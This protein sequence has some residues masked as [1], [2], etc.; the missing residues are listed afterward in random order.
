[1]MKPRSCWRRTA[2]GYPTE[3]SSQ[4]VFSNTP[5]IKNNLRTGKGLRYLTEKTQGIRLVYEQVINTMSE[6]K[7]CSPHSP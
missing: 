1:M 5:I 3:G 4:N 2:V 6:R 7:L